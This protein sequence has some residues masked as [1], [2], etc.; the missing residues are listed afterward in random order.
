[1]TDV[2]RQY[3]PSAHP[4]AAESA[5]SELSSRRRSLDRGTPWQRCGGCAVVGAADADA[6]A[7]AVM[8]VAAAMV[9]AA[10]AVADTAAA[11]D[12][13]NAAA[14]ADAAAAAAAAICGA[15]SESEGG[16]ERGRQGGCCCHLAPHALSPCG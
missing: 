13:A 4:A 3:D 5:R 9:V 15:P 14:A 11:A 1:M 2:D 16:R 6:N 7:D 12:A 10:D 8:V